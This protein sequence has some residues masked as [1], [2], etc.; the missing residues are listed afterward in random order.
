MDDV[1]EFVASSGKDVLGK[2]GLLTGQGSV[3]ATVVRS[4]VEED[5]EIDGD[6]IKNAY[7]F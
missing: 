3:E 5:F 2:G 6:L 4:C 7:V 1:C